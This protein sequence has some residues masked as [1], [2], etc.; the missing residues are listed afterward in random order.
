MATNKRVKDKLGK[1]ILIFYTTIIGYIFVV[2]YTYY[3]FMTVK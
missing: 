3:L 2:A 1:I